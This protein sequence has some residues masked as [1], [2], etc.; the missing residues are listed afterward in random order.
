MSRVA[1][2]DIQ[3]TPKLLGPMVADN[4]DAVIVPASRAIGAIC[5]RLCY[6]IVFRCNFIVVQ[7]N[8]HAI[9][10]IQTTSCA[11]VHVLRHDYLSSR[12]NLHWRLRRSRRR[13][14]WRLRSCRLRSWRLRSRCC[15]C[16]RRADG[17]C[18]ALAHHASNQRRTHRRAAPLAQSQ[19]VI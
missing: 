12:R 18:L 4:K 1:N 13:R 15:R 16:S 8:A 6:L 9:R 10:Q 19:R 14:S 7:S 5:Y 17:R 2:S 11:I 3:Q